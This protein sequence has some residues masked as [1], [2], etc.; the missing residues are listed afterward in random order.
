MA[1]TNSFLRAAYRTIGRFLLLL[2]AVSAAAETELFFPVL[3]PPPAELRDALN[4]GPAKPPV[5][6]AGAKRR[7]PKTA[8]RTN[9]PAPAPA[10]G[11]WAAAPASLLL[12]GDAGEIVNEIGL[13]EWIESLD[14]EFLRRRTMLGGIS[15]DGRF[16]WHWQ[17]VETIR[18]GSVD[19]VISSTTTLVYLGTAGQL[20]WSNGR[21][22]APPGLSP[23]ILDESGE[24]AFVLERSSGGNRAAAYTFTGNEIYAIETSGRL[25]AAGLTRNGRYAHVLWGPIGEPLIHTFLDLKRK[26]RIDL[27]AAETGPGEAAVLE[28]GVVRSGDRVLHRFP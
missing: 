25:E 23:V 26:A 15:T 10:C 24:T 17:K 20:L 21:A 6:G 4:A 11:Q 27:P 12:L 19:T 8:A 1:S 2:L 13:G 3:P 9:R 28:S 14:Q 16:A 18:R 7:C 5:D 22:D